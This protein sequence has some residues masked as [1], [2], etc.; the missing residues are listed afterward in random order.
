MSWVTGCEMQG[1]RLKGHDVQARLDGDALGAATGRTQSG[2]A[3]LTFGA[4]RGQEQERAE[5]AG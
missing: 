4:R 3:H 1:I 5:D 2:Q